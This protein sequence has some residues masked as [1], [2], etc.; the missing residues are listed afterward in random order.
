LK[1]TFHHFH[2]NPYLCLPI[3][4]IRV[5]LT[6]GFQEL[7]KLFFANSFKKSAQKKNP[8]ACMVIVVCARAAA[9]VT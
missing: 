6:R 5:V 4:I 8:S 1:Q 2:T 3:N 9:K 7:D